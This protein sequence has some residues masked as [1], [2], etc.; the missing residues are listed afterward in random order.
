MQQETDPMVVEIIR[1]LRQ[2]P[3]APFALVTRA[4]ERF[5]IAD[6]R[7]VAVRDDRVLFTDAV[8]GICFFRTAQLASIE[9]VVSAA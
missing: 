3:F 8:K 6:G 7:K 9:P 2:K 5:L 4:G 1:L